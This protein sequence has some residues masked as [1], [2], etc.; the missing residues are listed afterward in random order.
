MKDRFEKL[1]AEIVGNTPAEFRR[2][3]EEEQRTWSKV[4]KDTGVKAD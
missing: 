2:L 1:G 3:L 4:V